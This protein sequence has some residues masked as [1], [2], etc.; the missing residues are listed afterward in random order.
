MFLRNICVTESPAHTDFLDR[1]GGT[2]LNGESD[3]PSFDDRTR[4]GYLA[5]FFQ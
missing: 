4:G 2:A 3:P 5:G 1:L